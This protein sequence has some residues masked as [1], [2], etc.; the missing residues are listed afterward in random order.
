MKYFVSVEN[1]S[2]FYWQVELLIESFAM[3][4]VQEELVVAFAENDSQKIGGFSTNIVGHPNKFVHPNEGRERGYLPLNRVSAIRYALAYDA[5]EFPFAL[6]HA[7]MVMRS[8]LDEP[9][10]DYPSVVLNNFEDYPMSEE[11]LVKE[12]I[13]GDLERLAEERELSR[14]DLPAVPF[15]SPPIIF[16]KSF[17]SISE[18]FF[19]RLQNNM[20]DIL[21]RRGPS[22][23][24]E[25]AAWELTLAESFQ[26]CSISGS[27]LSA[28]LMFDSENSN[29]I[30]YRTGI[31]P[32]FH[33]KFYRYED[34]NYFSGQGPYETIMENNPTLSSD[35]LQ[36]VVKSYAD[37][38]LKKS[39]RLHSASSKPGET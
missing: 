12:E 10:G 38:R 24:C 34:G 1:T 6:I 20:L 35:F 14:K 4:G 17:K 28:P 27:F 16:S 32:V 37:G 29:F 11:S 13:F 25:K 39:R 15:F 26:H 18:V 30:H 31:P 19:S 5:I 23:P 9:K 22:F 8:P 2:Y 3:S 21:D 7:D 36:R 33:K